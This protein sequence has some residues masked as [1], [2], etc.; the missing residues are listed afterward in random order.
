MTHRR[1][2]LPCNCQM[3][4]ELIPESAQEIFPTQPM[5]SHHHSGLSRQGIAQVDGIKS[6]NPGTRTITMRVAGI[7]GILAL[8]R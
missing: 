2:G 5:G 7:V 6:I 3:H 8:Q 4:P 1:D